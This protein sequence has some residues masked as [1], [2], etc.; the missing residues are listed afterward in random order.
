MSAVQARARH[1]EWLSEI[2]T[3]ISNIR[4]ERKGEGSTLTQKEARALSGEWY[5]WY[6]A[7]HSESSL[8]TEYWE[9]CLEAFVNQIFYGAEYHRE[10]ADPYWDLSREWET[11]YEARGPARA[12]A[13]DCAETSQ[14]LHSKRI[15]LEPA[16][17]AQFLDFVCR[18]LFFALHVVIQRSR[19]DW[20]ED[21][22]PQQFPR[23]EPQGGG[24]LGPLAL[25]KRWVNE[26]NPAPSAVE[27]WRGVFLKMEEDFPGRSAASILPEEAQDWCRGLI[28]EARSA[29]TVNEVWKSA[30]RTVFKW[31][32]GQRLLPRNS[33]EEINITV[34]KKVRTRDG[35][36]FSQEEAKT[37]LVPRLRSPIP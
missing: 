14:F 5:N 30:A 26:R 27:R 29:A 16:S 19:G 36:A 23:Y 32:V 1:R 7:R 6:V 11:N 35:K 34:P 21:A 12:M 22:R 13:A 25:F 15:T 37:I 10:P 2:E 28:N 9:G 17:R 33:F 4:A 31:A 18:D 24:S 8:S 3:R 20:S